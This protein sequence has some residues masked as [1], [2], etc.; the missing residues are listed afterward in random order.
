MLEIEIRRSRGNL[1]SN[2]RTV[3]SLQTEKES[4]LKRIEEVECN[5]KRLLETLSKMKD[6]TENDSGLN[7]E[8]L[9]EEVTGL[10]TKLEEM[11]HKNNELKEAIT[12]AEVEID[13]LLKE[14]C[15]KI[16]KFV[17]FSLIFFLLHHIKLYF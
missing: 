16:I 7:K 15:C 3:L 13:S 11:G 14:R 4:L 8:S 9:Q 12:D 10:K 2:N 5:N 1:E 17:S 6:S